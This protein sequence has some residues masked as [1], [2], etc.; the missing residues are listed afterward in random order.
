MNNSIVLQVTLLTFSL[1]LNIFYLC[2]MSSRTDNFTFSFSICIVFFRG[3]LLWLHFFFFFGMV[4]NWSSESQQPSCFWFWGKA[5]IFWCQ[6]WYCFV[7]FFVKR[8]SFINLKTFPSIHAL[9]NIL[10]WRPAVFHLM[11]FQCP[12]RCLSLPFILLIQYVTWLL[13]VK[14]DIYFSNNSVTYGTQFLHF[15]MLWS[16]MYLLLKTSLVLL[17]WMWFWLWVI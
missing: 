11:L 10:S 13:A 6:E 16:F 2:Y 12:L 3:Q 4:L 7:S 5:F 15:Y 1:A 8:I 14:P 17:R 9:L